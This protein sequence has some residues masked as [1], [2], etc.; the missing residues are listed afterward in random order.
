MENNRLLGMMRFWLIG[1]FLIICVATTV[2]IAVLMH[3]TL[4]FALQ[5]S[6]PVWGVTAVLCVAWYYIYKL[7]LKRK[8]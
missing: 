1:T 2:Y 5:V 8:D 6:L 4:L 7:Y 3:E